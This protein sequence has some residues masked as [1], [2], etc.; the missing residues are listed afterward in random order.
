MVWQMA[1]FRFEGG[2]WWLLEQREAALQRRNCF[3]GEGRES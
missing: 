3:S 2:E 1:T